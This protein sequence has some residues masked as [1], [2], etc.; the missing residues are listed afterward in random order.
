MNQV[1]DIARSCN[2][3][4][5]VE[6]QIRYRL[7]RAAGLNNSEFELLTTLHHYGRPMNVKELAEEL[8]LCSQAITKITKRLQSLNMISLGKSEQDRRATMVDLM[9]KGSEIA[10]WDA[11]IRQ[12]L[13][14]HALVAEDSAG[15]S[16]FAS[17]M[18]ELE[19]KILLD[20]TETMKHV[21]LR[22]ALNGANRLPIAF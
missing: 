21:P 15:L 22:V 14:E 16:E 9:P 11:E 2:R 6:Q 5:K 19:T 20:G 1:T 7:A 8:L 17:A 13:F 3:I 4:S 12:R 10:V 18:R